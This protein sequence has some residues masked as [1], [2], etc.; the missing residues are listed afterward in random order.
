MLGGTQ[1]LGRQNPTWGQRI[2]KESTYGHRRDPLQR[3]RIPRN[4][5]MQ[6]IFK[7]AVLSFARAIAVALWI[8]ARRRDPIAMAG[9]TQIVSK[10]TRTTPATV[11]TVAT[12]YEPAIVQF[13]Q[14]WDGGC[15][16][17]RRERG[18][19]HAGPIPP[20]HSHSAPPPKPGR[21]PLAPMHNR[22]RGR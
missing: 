3:K 14:P 6:A 12:A 5:I 7:G 9:F 15:A 16:L 11:R 10:T 13:Q 4:Q 18:G 1:C 22:T 19:K 17:A 2:H 8:V 21:H 20:H